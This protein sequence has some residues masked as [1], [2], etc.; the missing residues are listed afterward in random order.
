MATFPTISE[1]P[2]IAPITKTIR[3]KTIVKSYA[4]E[5]EAVK[6]VWIFPKRN[7]KLK[8]QFLTIAET[9]VLWQFFLDQCGQYWPFVIFDSIVDQYIK[10]YVGIGNGSETIFNLPSKQASAYT[11]YL[12]GLEETNWTFNTEG[13][14]ETAD[15]AVFD[16]A[17]SDG[18][19]ITFSFTG[20]LK[21][22][23][24][25]NEDNLSFDQFYETLV[26]T[27]IE[28]RGLLNQ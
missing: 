24:R 15:Q 3:T 18:N 23:C 11:M 13:G 17:P 20:R 21:V 7:V 2:Y 8:Y 22:R 4:S 6:K 26:T 14:G 9:R 10:E 19:I 16:T 12:N 5:I 25:F 28:L 1:V 27:G